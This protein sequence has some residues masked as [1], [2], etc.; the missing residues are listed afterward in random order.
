[1]ESFNVDQASFVEETRQALQSGAAGTV[2]MG[3]G[4]PPA[5]FGQGGFAGGFDAG[6]T[7]GAGG[8]AGASRS[9]GDAA[10]FGGA[11]GFGSGFGSTFGSGSGLFG[12]AAPAA[13]AG[14]APADAAGGLDSLDRTRLDTAALPDSGAHASASSSSWF[15]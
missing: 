12:G 10:S 5:S 2:N 11:S 13:G 14:P 4:L 7:F 6:P 9:F 15:R 3:G 1:M 8:A